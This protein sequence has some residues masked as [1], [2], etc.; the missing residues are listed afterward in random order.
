[1]AKTAAQRKAA[2]RQRYAEAGLAEV[3][4]IYAPAADHAAIKDAAARIEMMGAEIQRLRS[5]ATAGGSAMMTDCELQSLRNLGNDAEAA[6]DEIVCLRAGL[7]SERERCAGL[8]NVTRADVSLAAGEMT[9][10]EWRT[11]AAVLRWMQSRIRS[12]S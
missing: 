12:S 11:V 10:Q 9:A 6:A 7:S 1:M 3:R 4:G 5:A 8:L 2:E